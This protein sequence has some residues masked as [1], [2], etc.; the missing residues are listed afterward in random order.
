MGLEAIPP[1]LTSSFRCTLQPENV[2]YI[3]VFW[4]YHAGQKRC[5]PSERRKGVVLIRVGCFEEVHLVV[6]VV[7]V[8]PRNPGIDRTKKGVV[9][10]ISSRGSRG[11][12][13]FV[14]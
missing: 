1:L 5:S 3:I 6:S 4:N 12:R 13:G 8:V 2:T 11:S 10:K 7:F 14:V 9:F